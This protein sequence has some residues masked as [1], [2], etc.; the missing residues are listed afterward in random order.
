MTKVLVSSV[1]NAPADVAWAQIRNFD[2]VAAW[3]PFV[4]S[5]PLESGDPT[6]PGAIRVVTQKDGLVFREVMVEHSDLERTYSYTFVR[7]PIHVSDHRTM[8]RLLP[9]TDGNR[10][11]A[12][13]TSQ[14]VIAAEREAELVGLMQKNFLAGLRALGVS[15]S[16]A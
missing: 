3:L 5:S 16:R 2:A 13:W 7:S 8:I 15:L 11:Y 14:F 9:I 4:A 10:T 6:D 12:E 1:L